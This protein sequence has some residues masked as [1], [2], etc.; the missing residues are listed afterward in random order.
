M[1]LLVLKRTLA[2]I[3]RQDL[4]WKGEWN[5]TAQFIKFV[6]NKNKLTERIH[7]KLDPFLLNLKGRKWRKLC[8]VPRGGWILWEVYH[9]LERM[10]IA[11]ISTAISKTPM[12][13]TH[14]NGK[15][16]VQEIG[17]AFLWSVMWMLTVCAKTGSCS[18]FLPDD[19]N[20]RLHPNKHFPP[21][22]ANPA[23]CAV[24]SRQVSFHAS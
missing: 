24:H 12:P 16:W 22:L 14:G 5:P 8:I 11:G 13:Q 6:A 2:S 18:F 15:W 17:K 4:E 9:C 7:D 10:C 1:F 3:Q 21:R 20:L 23:S 19:C